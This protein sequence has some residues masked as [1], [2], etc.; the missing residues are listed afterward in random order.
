MQRAILSVIIVLSFEIAQAYADDLTILNVWKL[1]GG[2]RLKGSERKRSGGRGFG[3]PVCRADKSE[4]FRKSWDLTQKLGDDKISSKRKL[5]LQLQLDNLK[6][7]QKQHR[8]SYQKSKKRNRKDGK[9][10][11]KVR[12]F[13]AYQ[14]KKRAQMHGSPGNQNS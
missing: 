2:K 3:G 5:L 1:R 14:A 6:K 10:R 7:R 12:K 11:R 8:E 4:R 13:K 9:E